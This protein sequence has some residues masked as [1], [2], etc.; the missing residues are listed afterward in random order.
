VKNVDIVSFLPNFLFTSFDAPKA[1]SF[2]LRTIGMGDIT[3][4]P[5]LS[6]HNGN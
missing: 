5:S 3:E 2:E 4:I 1:W 6:Y